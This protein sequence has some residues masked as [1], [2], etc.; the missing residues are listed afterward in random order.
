MNI[1]TRILWKIFK[2]NVYN[3]YTKQ[4]KIRELP[5]DK[6]QD[7]QWKRLKKLLSTS[8]ESSKFYHDLFKSVHLHPSDIKTYKDFT[9][10]PILDKKDLKSNYK[11]IIT[12][13]CSEQDYVVSYTS[14]STGEPFPFLIDIN[15]EAPNTFAA[16]MLNKENIGIDPFKKS[17]ELLIKIKPKNEIK[18]L[19]K[20]DNKSLYHKIKSHFISETFSIGSLNIKE[21]NTEAIS[22]IMQNNNIK[23]IYGYS[24]NVFSLA[25]FFKTNNININ[26][27]YVILIAESILPQQKSV[28]STIFKCPVYMDYGASECMRMGF[29]CNKHNGYHMDIYNYY[30]EYLDNFGEPCHPGENA[31]IVVTN[32]NNYIFPLIRYRIGDQI[33]VSEEKCSC[34]LPYPIISKISGRELNSVTT[35]QNNEIPFLN[36]TSSLQLF[37]DYIVQYQFIIDEKNENIT[38]KIIPNKEF[39]SEILQKI[40]GKILD[41]INHSMNVVIEVVEK[42]PCE[43]YGKTKAFIIKNR[44]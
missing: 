4:K 35:P 32:L 42:I 25:R 18:N 5:I 20:I 10:L 15:R 12:N 13:E 38:I 41:L 7:I 26:L 43:Q 29:E 8:F 17:N 21:E 19:N 9:K 27:N 3:S 33:I 37:Y 40:R 2:P 39:K 11:K 24:S 44:K 28:I 34:G 22:S 30:F 36:F 6:I 14:G 16:F 31:N 1:S 23:D